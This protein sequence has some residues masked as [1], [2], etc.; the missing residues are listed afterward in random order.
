MEVRKANL[1]FLWII[2]LLIFAQFFLGIGLEHLGI[3][4]NYWGLF[5]EFGVLFI[6]AIIYLVV[7]KKPIKETLR[8]NPIN[9]KSIA[10]IIII[11]IIAQPLMMFLSVFS[12]LLFHNYVA[13]AVKEMSSLPYV[14]LMGMMALSPAICEETVMRGVILSGYRKVD[15]R[16]AALMNGFLFGIFH[17]GPQQFLYA[18]ALGAVFVY[19]VEATNSIFASMLCHFLI[20]G[21]STTLAWIVGKFSDNKTEKTTEF[22]SLDPSVIIGT[23]VFLF[24]LALIFTSLLVLVIRE[25]DKTNNGRLSDRKLEATSFKENSKITKLMNWPVYVAITIYLIFTTLVLLLQ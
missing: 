13:D 7:T 9:M 10:I 14:V 11:A 22:S 17:L 25:L 23:L 1:F 12:Q 6:P 20:N 15:I 5:L 4:E 2:I 18:F 24:I 19:L 21:F 8:L 16:K 3:P